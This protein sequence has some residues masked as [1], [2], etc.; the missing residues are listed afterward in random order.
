MLAAG[1]SRD[2]TAH[3]TMFAALPIARER[4][5]YLLDVMRH[6]TAYGGL[7]AAAKKPLTLPAVADWLFS[8]GHASDAV[9]ARGDAA[10]LSF[11]DTGFTS[12]FGA[13]AADRGPKGAILNA[14]DETMPPPRPLEA[15][16]RDLSAAFA[17]VCAGVLM[18]GGHEVLYA[19]VRE[20]EEAWGAWLAAADD[21]RSATP[22]E[23]DAEVRKAGMFNLYNGMIIHAKLLFGHPPSLAK[24]GTFF[25]SAAYTV[26]GVRLSTVDLE[27]QVLRCKAGKSSVFSPLRLEAKEPRMHFVLNC[28]A[29]SCPPIRPIGCDTAEADIVFST[30]YFIE[31]HV[32]LDGRK[33]SLSRLFKWFRTD[34]TPNSLRTRALLAW[35]SGNASHNV[36]E[37]LLP[38][39][40]AIGQNED[41]DGGEMSP[42]PSVDEDCPNPAAKSTSQT[43]DGGKD[44]FVSKKS[45][46]T[47]RIKF[48]KYDWYVYF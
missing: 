40:S 46:G 1:T 31:K 2:R 42:Q 17:R 47:V 41:L 25:N 32:Q 4:R 16:L 26:C 36:R 27:H 19:S 45:D 5:L 20:Q 9:S 24:R 10:S 6:T 28:G 39:L 43:S 33:V 34:F 29:R 38:L 7:G 48:Q 13:L 3:P 21:L 30:L 15:V 23:M 22:G 12:H 8:A 35:I 18:R 44:A 14:L 11:A 37:M